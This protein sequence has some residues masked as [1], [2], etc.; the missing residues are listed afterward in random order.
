MSALCTCRFDKLTHF[1]LFLSSSIRR[2]YLFLCV[3]AVYSEIEERQNFLD[4]MIELGQGDKYI[5]QMKSE[6]AV[7]CVC[8]CV[9]I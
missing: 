7:V 8:V 4:E 1:C 9:C 3:C 6:I 5:G 2:C